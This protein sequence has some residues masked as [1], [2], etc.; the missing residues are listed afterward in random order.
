[1][2]D[3]KR[4]LIR[5]AG[6]LPALYGTETKLLRL[7]RLNVHRVIAVDAKGQFNLQSRPLGGDIAAK[8]GNNGLLKV[9]V[10]IAGK[11]GYG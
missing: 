3:G 6:A 7:H 1:M 8:A 4:R 5:V 9:L 2:A 11:R 10:S